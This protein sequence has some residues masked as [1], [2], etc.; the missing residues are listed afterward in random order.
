M[1]A[2]SFY[3]TKNLGALGD[4]GAI[5]TANHEFAA[6][7]RVMRDYGQSAKYRHDVVGYNSR[8]D[9]L[10]AGLMRRV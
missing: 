7:A 3:P 6:M 10:Q 5:L 2:T 1:A 4:G 9:E 8:L